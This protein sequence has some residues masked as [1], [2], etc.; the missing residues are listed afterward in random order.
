MRHTK[1][2]RGKTWWDLFQ[3]DEGQINCSITYPKE[4]RAFHKHLKKDDN[5]F[6]VKGEYLVVVNIDNKWERH[7]LSQGED[8]F[9]KRGVWHGFQNIGKEDG[10]MLYWE[11]EP[12][13]PNCTDDLKMYKTEYKEWVK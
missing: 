13:E 7:F 3:I 8:M 4:I 1:D 2:E 11:T 5:I 12:S 10:I 6:I 9:I